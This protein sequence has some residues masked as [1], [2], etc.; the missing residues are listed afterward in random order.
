MNRLGRIWRVLNLPCSEMTRLASE[1]LDHELDTLEWCALRSHLVYCKAC[2]RFLHQ[3]LFL[4]R[5]IKRQ[6]TRVETDDALPGPELP[7][8]VRERIKQALRKE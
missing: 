4:R 3:I 5:A 2:R 1:S 8:E 7:S 6:A